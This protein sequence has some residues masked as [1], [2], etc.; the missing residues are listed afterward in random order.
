MNA[1]ADSRK[2]ARFGRKERMVVF[3]AS[4]DAF[5]GGPDLPL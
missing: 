1:E 3:D 4:I 5:E 2:Y